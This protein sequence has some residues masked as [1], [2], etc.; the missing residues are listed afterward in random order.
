[1]ALNN[2]HAEEISEG[3]LQSLIENGVAEGVTIDYKEAPYGG[4]DV[5]RK[6]FLFDVSSFSNAAGGTLVIGMKEDHGIPVDL[7]GISNL[8]QIPWR[9]VTRTGSG[10]V[11]NLGFLA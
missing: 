4:S 11:S 8:E 1:M 5:D 3:D 9:S 2:K 10:T 6:E 7:C